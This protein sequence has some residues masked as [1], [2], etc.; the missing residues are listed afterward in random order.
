MLSSSSFYNVQI[1][2]NLIYMSQVKEHSL[3]VQADKV[4]RLDTEVCCGCPKSSS[5]Q[6]INRQK[7]L[8]YSEI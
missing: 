8:G 2:E 3:L 4:F 7:H 1:T 5:I 6:T